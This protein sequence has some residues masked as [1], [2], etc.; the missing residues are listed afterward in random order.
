M[1]EKNDARPRVDALTA[2]TSNKCADRDHSYR[3]MSYHRR[4]CKAS[5]EAIYGRICSIR[6]LYSE[7]HRRGT[8]ELDVPPVFVKVTLTVT[9]DI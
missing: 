2:S 9:R 5:S 4:H 6:V 1:R 7:R 8:I 3:Y